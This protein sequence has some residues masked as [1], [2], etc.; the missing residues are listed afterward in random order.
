MKTIFCYLSFWLALSTSVLGA[1]DSEQWGIA[2]NGVQM[3]ISLAGGAKDIKTNEPVKIMIRYR[4]VSTNEV[5]FV[6]KAN[7]IEFDQGYS[8]AVVSPSGKD[9]SPDMFSPASVSMGW[10]TLNPQAS[11]E[12]AFNLSLKCSFNEN[13][14]YNIV[15]TKGIYSVTSQKA[16]KVISNPLSVVVHRE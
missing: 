16:F 4:N 11:T 7:A 13:G 2:T 8:W 6:S 12:I 3:S 15:A 1:G 10:V 14:T 9:I 5:V